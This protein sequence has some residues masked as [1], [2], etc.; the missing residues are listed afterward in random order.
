MNT[1]HDVS[2][3]ILTD[4]KG[5]VLLQQKTY[6]APNFPGVWSLFGGHREGEETPTETAAR[7]VEEELA[8]TLPRSAFRHIK[9]FPPEEASGSKMRSVFCIQL[10]ENQKLILREGRGMGYFRNEEIT[11]LAIPPHIRAILAEYFAAH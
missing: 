8:L 10:E 7:E 4:H 11:H 5:L 1:P 9:D 6:D 2:L 3:V